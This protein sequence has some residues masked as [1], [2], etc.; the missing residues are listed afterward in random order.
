MSICVYSDVSERYGKR[1]YA[2]VVVADQ[3]Y[4]DV[5]EC[6]LSREYAVSEAEIAA[7]S[8]G[9]ARAYRRSTPAVPIQC[10]TD[11]DHIITALQL[12]RFSGTKRHAQLLRDLHALISQR[13]NVTILSVPRNHPTYRQ[14]HNRARSLAK[15]LGSGGRVPPGQRMYTLPA[16]AESNRSQSGEFARLPSLYTNGYT[17]P[18]PKPTQPPLRT[19]DLLQVVFDL[20][21]TAAADADEARR[22]EART[23]LTLLQQKYSNRFV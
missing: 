4:W 1:C 11:I 23:M 20:G 13:D 18:E 6:P 7:L 21:Q 22:S 8:R 3:E 16:Q 15:R 2:T 10:F 19:A 17:P 9:L 5:D 12:R 14:C